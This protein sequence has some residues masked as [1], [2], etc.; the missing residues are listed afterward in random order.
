MSLEYLNLLISKLIEAETNQIFL[1][2]SY[3]QHIEEKMTDNI[4]V[5]L[6]VEDDSNS[7]DHFC[8]PERYTLLIWIIN[9]DDSAS[10]N[11][12]NISSKYESWPSK[13]L[14]KSDN[15]SPSYP[16]FYIVGFVDGLS[17]QLN[18]SS[19]IAS[20]WTAETVVTIF[21]T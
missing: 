2:S 4:I 16:D 17:E 13:T 3:K 1:Y 14:Y 11:N 15:T 8:T 21:V 6:T 10:E 19:N 7:D 20:E 9:F 5:D 18:I 12:I